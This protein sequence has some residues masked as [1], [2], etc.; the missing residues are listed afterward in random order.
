MILESNY[1]NASNII[2]I[3]ITEIIITAKILIN[4]TV[5][6]VKACALKTFIMVIQEGFLYFLFIDAG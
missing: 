5:S 4:A 6:A 3:I 2:A 1:N